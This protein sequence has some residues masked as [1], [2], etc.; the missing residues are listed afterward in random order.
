MQVGGSAGAPGVSV[1]PNP[2]ADKLV[3]TFV[4]TADGTL[5]FTAGPRSSVISKVVRAG[6]NSTVS[7]STTVGNAYSLQYRSQLNSSAWTTDTG[8]G[9]ITGNGGL[10]S[11]TR[12]NAGTAEFYRISTQ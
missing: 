5:T 6:S 12:T 1:Y 8:A 4:I 2:P 11:L 9:T 10:N 7:F 3:G